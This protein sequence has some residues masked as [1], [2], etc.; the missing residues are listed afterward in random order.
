[1]AGK[2]SN[3]HKQGDVQAKR[4]LRVMQIIFVIFSIMIILAMIL[5]AFVTTV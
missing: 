1:M 4:R 3:N 2:K 5:S